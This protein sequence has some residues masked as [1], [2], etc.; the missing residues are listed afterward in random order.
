MTHDKS[1]EKHGRIISTLEESGVEAREYERMILA[2]SLTGGE[3]VINSEMTE[4]QALLL[5]VMEAINDPKNPDGT[6][7]TELSYDCPVLRT[8][9]TAFKKNMISNKRK[10]RMEIKAVMKNEEEDE[11]FTGRI[12]DAIK[13][14]D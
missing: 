12:K 4:Q 13:G 1:L 9:N 5:A 10:G 14:G 11:S 2:E 6:L 3:D 7:D 8:F